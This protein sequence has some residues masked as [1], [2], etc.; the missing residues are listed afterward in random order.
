MQAELE[1]K[2]V[3]LHPRLSPTAGKPGP[4]PRDKAGKLDHNKAMTGDDLRDFVDRK[5]FP[6]L[7]RLQAA[8]SGPNT[9][10]YKI[11]EIFAE[12]KNKIHSG[13]N[14]RND[15]RPHRRTALPLAD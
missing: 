4:P 3:R 6:Y 5:L 9:I 7:T 13:Y 15:H 14:L 8:R 11:G 12:I 10:E 2:Q 1:G